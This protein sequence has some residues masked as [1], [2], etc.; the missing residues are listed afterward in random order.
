MKTKGASTRVDRFPPVACP[1]DPK[2]NALLEVSRVH[3]S[4]VSNE[5]FDNSSLISNWTPSSEDMRACRH[6]NADSLVQ[7]ILATRSTP[8]SSLLPKKTGPAGPAPP[9]GHTATA[10]PPVA[11]KLGNRQTVARRKQKPSEFQHFMTAAE[12]IGWYR[13]SY[14]SCPTLGQ[15]PHFSRTFH[16]SLSIAQEN[17]T[18][19]IDKYECNYSVRS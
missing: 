15:F 9:T 11:Q 2:I 13:E 12:H 17:Y 19:S 3:C 4:C 6:K 1:V 7:V 5:D 18:I 14:T 16:P 10:V 8:R